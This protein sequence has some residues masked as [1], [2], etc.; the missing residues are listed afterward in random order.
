VVVVD[1]EEDHLPRFIGEGLLD[2]SFCLCAVSC[3]AS[4]CI[5]VEPELG[6]MGVLGMALIRSL[7]VPPRPVP[8]VLCSPPIIELPQ[9]LNFGSIVIGSAADDDVV[10]SERNMLDL[11]FRLTV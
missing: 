3:S 7:I 2:P 10:L 11:G 8:D 1:L 6:N 5:R 4:P 9:E